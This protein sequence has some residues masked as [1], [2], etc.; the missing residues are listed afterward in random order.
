[1]IAQRR[2][3]NHLDTVWTHS[4]RVNYSRITPEAGMVMKKASGMISHLRQGVGKSFRSPQ[5]RDDGGG[6]YGLLHGDLI[7]Y[8]GFL[9][10]GAFIGE[11]ARSV[12]SRG[13]HTWWQ[14]ALGPGRTSPRCGRL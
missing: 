11:W 4:P 6:G 2:R 1:M 14:R 7:G 5:S 9:H 12:G 8:L 3:N 10:R 13:D